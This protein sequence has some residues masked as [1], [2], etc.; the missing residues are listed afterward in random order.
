MVSVTHMA[1]IHSAKYSI[2]DDVSKGRSC[3][4]ENYLL[5]LLVVNKLLNL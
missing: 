2:R 5:H 3:E 4:I 1:K